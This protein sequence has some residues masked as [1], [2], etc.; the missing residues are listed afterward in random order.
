[1]ARGDSPQV[2]ANLNTQNAQLGTQS[3]TN[4]QNTADLAR[5]LADMEML[6]GPQICVPA[7]I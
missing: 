1:M 4:S 3:V 6:L 2:V 7:S 5:R